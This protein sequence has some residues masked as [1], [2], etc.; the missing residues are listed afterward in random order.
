MKLFLI[1]ITVLA[2]LFI[3]ESV[4]AAQKIVK[5]NVPGMTCAVCPVTVKKALQNVGGVIIVSVNFE[6]K[7]ALITFD[8]LKTNVAQLINATTDA[9][10]PSTVVK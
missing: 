2:S 4:L 7:F 1:L 10:Y 8:D 6:K 5:L 9:G 3:S